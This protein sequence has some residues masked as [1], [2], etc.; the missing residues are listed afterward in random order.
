MPYYSVTLDGQNDF[1]KIGYFITTNIFSNNYVNAIND[2][3][4]KIKKKL[5]KCHGIQTN[6][7]EIINIEE[8]YFFKKNTNFYFYNL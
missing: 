7:F 4:N 1:Q 2:A 6:H 8:I 5:K 3:K